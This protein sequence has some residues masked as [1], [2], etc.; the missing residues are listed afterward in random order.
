MLF[1]INTFVGFDVADLPIMGD[2]DVNRVQTIVPFDPNT[3]FE[4]RHNCLCLNELQV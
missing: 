4:G 2:S 3:D 1:F